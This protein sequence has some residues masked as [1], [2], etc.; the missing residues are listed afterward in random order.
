[1]ARKLK[2]AGVRQV[3]LQLDGFRPEVNRLMRGADLAEEKRRAARAVLDAGMALGLVAT[4]TRHNLDELPAI[5]EFGLSLAPGLRTIIFQAAAPTGRF[6]LPSSDVVD[7]EEIL[8]ALLESGVIPG[9]GFSSVR[10]LPRVAS[11]GMAVHPDCVATLVVLTGRER[12]LMAER[13]LD[14]DALH[15]RFRQ[16]KGTGWIARNPGALR[17]LLASARSGCRGKLLR[18]L[19]GFATGRGRFGMVIIGVGAYCRSDFLDE[20]RLAGCGTRE[21]TAVGAVSPCRL[22]LGADPTGKQPPA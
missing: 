8:A 4:L 16:M 20:A 5:V 14:F 18:H 3:S 7:K 1:L 2:K 10:P 13:F 17:H 11:W 21:M 22:Y 6:D 12:P 15:R 19:A 9:A